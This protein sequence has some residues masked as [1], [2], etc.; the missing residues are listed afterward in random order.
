ML[1]LVNEG[2]GALPGLN[3][4]SLLELIGQFL[5]ATLRLHAYTRL[6]TGEA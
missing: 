6:G 5:F 2:L 4:Q 3:L 1:G